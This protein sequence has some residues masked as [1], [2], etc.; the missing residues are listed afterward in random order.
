MGDAHCEA[1]PDSLRSESGGWPVQV[2]KST[3][4]VMW[5]SPHKPR[6]YTCACL[7]TPF[8]RSGS[9][10]SSELPLPKA[11]HT[12]GTARVGYAGQAHLGFFPLGGVAMVDRPDSIGSAATAT[13][14]DLG[15]WVRFYPSRPLQRTSDGDLLGYQ[16]PASNFTCRR[17]FALLLRAFHGNRISHHGR[18]RKRN[19]PPVANERLDGRRD[20]CPTCIGKSSHRRYP[21]SIREST[22]NGSRHTATFLNILPDFSP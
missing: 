12:A 15:K 9:T 3:K 16:V 6:P 21:S 14:D 20:P 11:P 17:T 5:Q 22:K 19:D 13:G 1:S 10:R 18:P 2:A 4:P 7:G 8:S